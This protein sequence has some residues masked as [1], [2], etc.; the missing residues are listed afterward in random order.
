MGK[1]LIIDE[2]KRSVII[3]SNSYTLRTL[4]IKREDIKHHKSFRQL[5]NEIKLFIK[6]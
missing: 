3:E 1:L 4:G 6:N 5:N 2:M